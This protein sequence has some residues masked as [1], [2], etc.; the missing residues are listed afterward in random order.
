[1]IYNF[2]YS[3][4]HFVPSA[5]IFLNVL[6]IKLTHLCWL[7]CVKLLNYY[8]SFIISAYH[9]KCIDPWLTKNRRVCPVCKRK[10]FAADEQVVTDESDSDD[11]TAPLIRDG[12]QGA[13]IFFFCDQCV[14]LAI[15]S[16]RNILLGTQGGTFARQRE[17]PFNRARRSQARHDSSNS[18]DNSSDSEQSYVTT[19]DGVSTSAGEPSNVTV[20]MVSDSHSINGKTNWL[21]VLR[22]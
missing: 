3:K 14:S 15:N 12:H 18:S 2:R 7:L 17:N 11:D 22:V 21:T 13:G 4:Q 5:R 6:I 20:F 16:R 8:C 1:M 10:V 9:S 19:E